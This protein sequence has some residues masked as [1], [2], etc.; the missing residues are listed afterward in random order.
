[1]D[2]VGKANAPGQNI[3]AGQ[4]VP[5]PTGQANAP[6]QAIAPGQIQAQKV[7]ASNTTIVDP[8]TPTTTSETGNI[9]EGGWGAQLYRPTQFKM[10]MESG[11]SRMQSEKF[12]EAMHFFHVAA[13]IS[14]ESAGEAQHYASQAQ[15]KASLMAF[16]TSEGGS[17]KVAVVDPHAPKVEP[18][19]PH[20]PVK[21]NNGQGGPKEC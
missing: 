8:T 5:H 18:K 11:Q 10:A 13:A 9:L 12:G 4:G 14:P 20:A 19:D 17:E 1:M 7:D 2:A 16:V 6:G 3:V 15:Y 21:D